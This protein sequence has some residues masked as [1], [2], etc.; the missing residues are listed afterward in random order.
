[1]SQ[2]KIVVYTQT[3]CP[4]CDRAK[5]LLKNKGLE[6]E[7]INLDGKDDERKALVEKT[8]MRTVPQIFI[9]DHFVGGSQELS[10]FEATGELDR[11]L[12]S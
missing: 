5:A 10:A 6:F 11:L 1:M 8:G 4:Y 12:N 9:G 7:E 3:I 2:K